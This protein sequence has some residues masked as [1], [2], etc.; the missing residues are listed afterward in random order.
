MINFIVTVPIN[1]SGQGANPLDAGSSW[2]QDI[3]DL[4]WCLGCSVW[5]RPYPLDTWRNNPVWILPWRGLKFNRSNTN[6]GFLALKVHGWQQLVLVPQF[7]TA[8]TEAEEPPS[9]FPSWR[10]WRRSSRR[11]LLNRGRERG[12]GCPNSSGER[13]F[14]LE[15]ETYRSQRRFIV[16]LQMFF[17]GFDTDIQL[18]FNVWIHEAVLQLIFVCMC[19]LHLNPAPRMHSHAQL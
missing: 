1:A 15:L 12:A 18:M 8:V 14:L 9:E 2:T 5:R 10:F 13:I 11:K 17:E 3:S 7:Q 4:V 6:P 19:A 16:L